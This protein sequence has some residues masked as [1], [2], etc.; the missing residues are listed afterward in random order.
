MKNINK[1]LI[2]K[3][4]NKNRLKIKEFGVKNI[5]LFGSYARDE[6]NENSDIDFLVEFRKNRGNYDDYIKLMHFLEDI[7]NKKIDLIEKDYL[8]EELKPYVF[9]DKI[10]ETRV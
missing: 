10:Y 9:G 2:L 7:F 8:R 1:E 4:L 5:I 3:T 6:Q